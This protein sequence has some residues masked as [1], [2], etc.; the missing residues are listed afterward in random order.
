LKKGFFCSSLLPFA[1]LARPFRSSLPFRRSPF[2]FLMVFSLDFCLFFSLFL[3]FRQR[4]SP[5]Y[6][7][8]LFNFFP[9]AYYVSSFFTFHL[10][11]VSHHAFLKN[12]FR[13]IPS[14]LPKSPAW[15]P[16]FCRFFKFPPHRASTAQVYEFVFAHSFSFSPKL[17]FFL[18]MWRPTPQC[19]FP[20]IHLRSHRLHLAS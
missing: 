12:W 9:T 19:F 13:Q 3:F 18:F 11:T 5:P 14:W 1:P 4:A 17:L 15:Q 16:L 6:N 7:L 10:F 20:P 2:A 8:A